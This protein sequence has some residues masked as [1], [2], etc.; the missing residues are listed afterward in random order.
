MPFCVSRRVARYLSDRH[1]PSASL[2]QLIALAVLATAAQAQNVS[3]KG[4]VAQYD[5]DVSTVVTPWAE[6]QRLLK[7]TLTTPRKPGGTKATHA[8]PAS[9]SAANNLVLLPVASETAASGGLNEKS[10]P[11]E[12][13]KPRVL[14]YWG[15]G[16]TVRPGQPLVLDTSKADAKDYAP[17]LAS[18]NLQSK[19]AE[20]SAGQSVWPNAT[21]SQG[22][23]PNSSLVGTH[24]LSGD[25][26]PARLQFYLT[27]QQDFLPP[28]SLSA[29]GVGDASIALS[30]P[31]VANAR[32]YFLSAVGNNDEET[33]VWS[34]SQQAGS[35][36]GVLDTSQTQCAIPAG[37]FSKTSG[38]LLQAVANGQDLTIAQLPR[39]GDRRVTSAPE[40]SA[41]VRVKSV[42]WLAL[43]QAPL[44]P[45]AAP[46]PV[47][48]PPTPELPA[49]KPLP[50][51]IPGVPGMGNMFKGLF[52]R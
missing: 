50:P 1:V 16:T 12:V 11:P 3:P 44:P 31:E 37:I 24:V 17:F 5:M 28:W 14:L 27:P 42:G 4:A 18:R 35:N 40:W 38:A 49:E 32:S 33:V 2:M 26:V 13:L 6:P 22:V 23:A 47:Q 8:L 7:L 19:T 34:S 9:A 52:G 29:S 43:S 46:T 10:I 39:T 15:C 25:G 51:T 21:H 41:R 36:I 45:A 48:P 20:L 30:W